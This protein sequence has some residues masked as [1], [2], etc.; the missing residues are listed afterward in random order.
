MKRVV[1]VVV[2]MVA[3]AGCTGV[4]IDT[5]ST[6]QASPETGQVTVTAVVDGDT[7]DI[8]YANGT[9]ERV[10]LLGIDTPEVQAEN[11]PDEFE[12]V[13][14]TAAGERC[15]RE[16]GQQ[17][18]DHLTDRLLHENVRLGFDD[19]ADRRG[20]YGRLLAY[21]FVD[22][23]N[24]NYRLVEDGYARV[25]DTEFSQ[26]PRFYEAEQE[27]KEGTR[28]VWRCADGGFSETSSGTALTVEAVHADAAGND[29][30][31]LN[32]EYVVL[33]NTGET[34]L[35]MGGWTIRDAAGNA[36]V[37]PETFELPPDASLT[38]YT[39]S[40]TDSGT[41]LYWGTDSAVWN[42]GGDRLVVRDENGT[43][44]LEYEY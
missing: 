8:R 28:G 18:S 39:G 19:Q 24:V 29:H 43:T 7:I 15:L 16:A 42:N 14:D 22:E 34:E 11:T 12:G 38:L 25:Y 21:V 13:P 31:N 10:R 36:Y 3:L 4:P 17:A 23:T 30:E 44:V 5:F 33:Q 41:E 27:A 20:S 37:V 6:T 26:A 2:V 40:G 32:D 35:D 1:S 9:V